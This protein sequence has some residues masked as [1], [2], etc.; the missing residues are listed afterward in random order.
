MAADT[1][2][3]RTLL[4]SLSPDCRP[5]GR[6]FSTSEDFSHPGHLI[7]TA[8]AVA[9]ARNIKSAVDVLEDCAAAHEAIMSAIAALPADAE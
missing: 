5:K 9:A 8:M 7:A 4:A 6:Q 3:K 1:P 2:P